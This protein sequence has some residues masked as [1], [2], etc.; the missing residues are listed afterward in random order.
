MPVLLYHLR[1]GWLLGSRFL[2][3]GHSGR[4]T[5]MRHSTVLE[6]VDD[7]SAT[8]TYV[9]VSGWGE[10]AQWLKNITVNPD[11]DV[12]L[13]T[14]TR[15]ARA[16]RMRRNEAESALRNYSRSHPR[17]ARQLARV[18]LGGPSE[19]LDVEIALLA[20]LVPLVELRPLENT[21]ESDLT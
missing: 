14:R 2:L 9:V 11:V 16:R 4:K 15:R 19:S 1:L 7:V 6:I 5:G 18:I 21:P 8:H 3:L 17:A 20:A 12:T 13:G 10:S